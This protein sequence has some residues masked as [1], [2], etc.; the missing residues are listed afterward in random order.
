MLGKRPGT[1]GTFEWI[2]M[3]GTDTDWRLVSFA[4]GLALLMESRG[5]IPCHEAVAAGLAQAG[6]LAAPFGGTKIVCVGRNYRPH[7]EEMGNAVPKEPLWFMKPPSSVIGPGSEIR[8]P[9][10]H[11]R[12]DYEGEVALVIGETASCV[13]RETA[14]EK[15]AGITV[16]LDVTARDLQK[17]DGQWTRAKG[18]DTFCPVGP[19]ILPFGAWA[20]DLLLKT[21]LNGKTVQNDRTSSLVFSYADLIAHLSE[22][23]TLMPGD[24]I[25][26]GTPAGIG[27]LRSGDSISVDIMCGDGMANVPVMRLSMHVIDRPAH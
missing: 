23:M 16:A 10:A 2:W 14:T 20:D 17:S 26:T 18:F 19:V 15:I 3:S 27:A 21:E 8:L 7:A 6:R 12:I 1:D 24:V 11:G 5:K 13:N 9:T 4:E 25:L 22:C